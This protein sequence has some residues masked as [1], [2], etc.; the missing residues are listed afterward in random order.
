LVHRVPKQWLVSTA[1]SSLDL[2]VQGAIAGLGG[3]AEATEVARALLAAHGSAAAEP[4][5][6]RQAIGVVR[7]VV[8]ADLARGGDSRFS[9]RRIGQRAIIALE[10]DDPDAPGADAILDWVRQLA[11]A[12]DRLAAQRPIPVRAAALAVLREIAMP[13]HAQPLDDE[14]LLR[15]AAAASRTAAVGSRGEVYPRGLE[16]EESIRLTLAGFSAARLALTPQALQARVTGRFPEAAALPTRPALDRL[17]E[18]IDPSLAWNG[19]AYGSSASGTG[20]L[21]STQHGMT[22]LGNRLV[23]APFNQVDARLRAS[24]QARGYLTLAVDPRRQDQAAG[25]LADAYGL[26]VVN[27]T[28]VLMSA[29]RDLAASSGVDWSFLLS[30]DAQDPASLDRQQLNLFV[31]QALEASLP[32]ILAKQKPLLLVDPAPLGRY[33]QQHWLA[34]LADLATERPAARWLL[35]PHRDSAGPPSLDGHVPV[36]LGADG[37]LAIGKD[38]IDSTAQESA[39]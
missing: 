1:E 4:E 14:R 13:S 28:Q 37:Y 26:E 19:T 18:A 30:V 2:E 24:L 27:L 6:T 31:K 23:G 15:I 35:I 29:A 8:E 5:R 16:P 22:M 33:G 39:S 17:L 12:A 10:P 11:E 7:I 32:Q 36:P 34:R 3:I 21:L 25:V 9:A 20:S 38:V